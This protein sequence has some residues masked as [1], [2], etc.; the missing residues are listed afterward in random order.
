MGRTV[1]VTGT[2]RI[3][4][5][6]NSLGYVLLQQIWTLIIPNHHRMSDKAW[7]EQNSSRFLPSLLQRIL[8]LAVKSGKNANKCME[9]HVHKQSGVSRINPS[10]AGDR[11]FREINLYIL[12]KVNTIAADALAPWIT[13]KSAA[14]VLTMKN[15]RL[16]SWNCHNLYRQNSPLIKIMTLPSYVTVLCLKMTRQC[17]ETGHQQ[18]RHWPSSSWIF[19]SQQEMGWISHIISV[20]YIVYMGLWY[21]ISTKS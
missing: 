16:L 18:I 17:K 19:W 14:M 11:I 21:Y 12:W 2:R 10:G 3:S 15:I 6:R 1:C 5:S 4:V 9:I 7:N 20:C 8:I 13:R